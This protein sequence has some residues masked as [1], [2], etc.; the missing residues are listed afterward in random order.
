[1]ISETKLQQKIE[2]ISQKLEL[3]NITIIKFLKLISSQSNM[4]SQVL[5]RK[6][7]LPQSHLYRLIQEFS[8]ILSPKNKFIS[9]NKE[10]SNQ[11][12]LYVKKTIL[13]N[14]L[15]N[16]K[17]ATIIKEILKDIQPIRPKPNRDLDQFN[18]TIATTIKR[19]IK[20]NKNGDLHNKKIAFLGD[21]DLDSVGAALSHLC[22]KVTVFEIDDRLNK[23]ITKINEE[24]DLDIEV[25][26]QDLRQSLDDKYLNKYDI[27][28]T[29][30]PYTKEG[31]NLFLNQAIKLIKKSYL[32]R[33]Y[34]CYGNSDRAREREI[35]IQNLIL[36]HNLIIKSK[37]YQ[38]NKYHGAQSIGS[39]SS[40]YVLDWTPAT[41]IIQSDFIKIYTND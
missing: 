13:E 6:T 32:G 3:R 34:L 2:N 15:H 25:V 17:L 39:Q 30:P 36:Q 35:E 23:L 21:D 29:D 20:L 41:K 16:Q 40:L 1:M 24:N 18:A 9:I 14:N 8:D 27:V 7:G 11:V 38:F 12:S 4:T 5:I 31:I 33:I 22:N 37:H 19:I 28:F 10:F 26:K